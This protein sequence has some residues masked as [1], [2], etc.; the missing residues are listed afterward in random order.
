MVVFDMCANGATDDRKIFG[1]KT[2]ESR[3]PRP[4]DSVNVIVDLDID[5]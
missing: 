4:M 1:G 3:L 2:A 5:L